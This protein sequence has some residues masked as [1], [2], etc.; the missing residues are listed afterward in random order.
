MNALFAKQS[1]ITLTDDDV[2]GMAARWDDLPHTIAAMCEV[3]SYDPTGATKIYLHPMG[4]SGAAN[5]L[6]R[7]CHVDEKICQSVMEIMQEEEKSLPD[8]KLY[9]EIVHLPESRI[10]NILA[11]PVLRPYEVPYLAKAGVGKEFQLEITDLMVSV[12]QRKFVL[13]SKRLNKEIIPR[14]TSAHNFSQPSVMPIY[15][16]LCN[17]QNQ[18]YRGGMGLFLSSLFNEFP[19]L[20]RITYKNVIL[21]LAR[22]HVKADDLKQRGEIQS[23]SSYIGS[24]IKNAN[25]N[26]RSDQTT[27]RERRKAQ[28]S[29]IQLHPHDDEPLVPQQTTHARSRGV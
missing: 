14:L 2:K 13:R 18:Y 11:R 4:G 24:K 7:F 15:Q 10:G 1:E 26:R 16:F 21:S 23:H 6:G 25:T 27:R 19:Y 12:R 29:I 3:F 8:D 22:W 17:L 20:P 9:A 5:L 28:Q